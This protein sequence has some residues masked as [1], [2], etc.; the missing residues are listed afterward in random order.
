MNK[1]REAVYGLRRQLMEGRTIRRSSSRRTTSP[2]S[3]RTFSTE[4][5]PE[6]ANVDQWKTDEFFNAIY[7]QFGARL[8]NEIDV[9]S[10]SRHDLGETIFEHASSSATTSRSRS[11]AHLECGT[12][13]AS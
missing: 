13:S 7:E 8:E 10:V 1:Q 4:Y 2:R 3:S 11:S 12:T 6:K 5:I 9:H